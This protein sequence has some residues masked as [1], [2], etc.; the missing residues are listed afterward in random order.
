MIC[1]HISSNYWSECQ[2]CMLYPQNHIQF[3]G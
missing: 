2:L 1:M 3:V